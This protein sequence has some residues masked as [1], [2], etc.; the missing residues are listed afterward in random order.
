MKFNQTL[1]ESLRNTALK[2]P[3]RYALLFMNRYM[4][5]KNLLERVDDLAAGFLE[6]GIKKKK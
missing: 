1:Y 2:Y 5:Y 6:I 3:D 4:D